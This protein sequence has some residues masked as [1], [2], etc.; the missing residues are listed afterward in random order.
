[1]L[2]LNRDEAV[3]RLRNP[4]EEKLQGHGN[5]SDDFSSLEE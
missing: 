1:M 2:P 4:L 3:L 5:T